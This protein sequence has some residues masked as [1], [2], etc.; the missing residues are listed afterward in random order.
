MV[1]GGESADSYYDEGVTASMKGEVAQAVR[2]FKK[3]MQLDPYHVSSCHQLGKCYVR[4]GRLQDAVEC[5]YRAIKARPNP[6]PPRLDLGY[7]LLEGGNAERAEVAFNEV[8][9][10]KPENAKA[11]LGL[12]GCA[13][14]KGQWDQAYLLVGQVLDQGASSFSAL[15]LRGR[16]ARLAG[17]IADSNEAFESADRLL[18]KLIEGNPEQPEGYYLRGELCFAQENFAAA[19]DAYQQ[20]ESR[21]VS[22]A[23]YYTY[24]EH[25]DHIGVLGKRAMCLFRLERKDEARALGETIQEQDPDNR[26]AAMLTQPD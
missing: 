19:L 4:L 11:L 20:A 9:E 10:R 15:Y 5:F 18:E 14:Q 21:L 8:M 26:I 7:A 22:D 2:H 16:A 17:F 1:F 24:G 13:F 12:A 3:A 23:H 25:F 6:I